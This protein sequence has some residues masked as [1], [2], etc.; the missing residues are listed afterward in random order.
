MG[1][2][3]LHWLHEILV[4][5]SFEPRLGSTSPGLCSG[6]YGA[7]FLLILI[8]LLKGNEAAWW[9]ALVVHGGVGAMMLHFDGLEMT[10]L[11][12]RAGEL[13]DPAAAA[14]PFPPLRAAQLLFWTS[15]R[16]FLHLS[17]PVLLL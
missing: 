15:S 13:G 4:N 8:G 16:A 6:A 10:C 11:L 9:I 7:V 17:V 14:S 5:A 1:I 3:C 12:K 2:L